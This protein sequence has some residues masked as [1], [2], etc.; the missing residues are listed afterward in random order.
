[1]SIIVT[2]KAK[3]MIDD[4]V[5]EVSDFDIETDVHDGSRSMGPELV[6]IVTGNADGHEV[7]WHVYEYPAGDINYADYQS[8]YELVEKPVFLPQPE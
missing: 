4:E 3:V 5:I 1:M 2:G 8:D 6:H 7:E